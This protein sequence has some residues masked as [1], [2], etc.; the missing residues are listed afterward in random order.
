MTATDD[1]AAQ[2]LLK[3]Y[4]YA[5]GNGQT[6]PDIS[7][8][9]TSTPQIVAVLAGWLSELETRWPGPETEGR[10]LARLTL[11]NALGRK[12]ARKSDAVPALISQ[13]DLTKQTSSR[14]RWAAGNAL[15]DIP[16]DSAYFDQLAA[17]A[18]NREFGADRQMVISWL[19]KSR[20]PN[21]AALALSQLDDE[22]VQGH[23]LDALAR[24]RAQGVREQI[25]PFLTSKNK[26]HRRSAER[27]ARYDQS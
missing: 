10:E 8:Q 19:A 23:V 3:D 25:E 20:H 5:G 18:T 12:E 7:R 1:A 15:C 24:L 6:I 13:F 16:A 17:I 21:A 26:W 11:A 14:A 2:Q 9:P 27:I 22:T 4:H